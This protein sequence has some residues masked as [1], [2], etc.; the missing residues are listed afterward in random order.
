MRDEEKH[1]SRGSILF[2]PHPF[3]LIP[4]FAGNFG[5]FSGILTLFRLR[6]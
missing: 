3:A 6:L 1:S 4:A 5:A 2:I